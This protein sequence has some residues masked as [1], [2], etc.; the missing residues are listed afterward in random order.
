MPN[1]E[2]RTLNLIT[3]EIEA[4]GFLYNMVRNIVG[5][6]VEIGRGRFP[7]GS[8]KKVLRLKNRK[9]AGPTAPARGLALLKVK[10]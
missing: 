6:L 5:T 9:L 7:E 1:T 8:T 10:Y 3:V 4:D 2:H